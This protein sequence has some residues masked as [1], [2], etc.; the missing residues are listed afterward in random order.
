MWLLARLLDAYAKGKVYRKAC[1]FDPLKLY[2]L[3]YQ[4]MEMLTN[5]QDLSMKMEIQAIFERKLAS[6][7]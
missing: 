2:N 1:L 5:E 4:N 3:L 6:P 7:S